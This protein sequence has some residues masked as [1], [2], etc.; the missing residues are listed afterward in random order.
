MRNTV[1]ILCSGAIL[2]GCAHSGVSSRTPSSTAAGV[3]TCSL[4]SRNTTV[5]TSQGLGYRPVYRIYDSEHGASFM[6]TDHPGCAEFGFKGDD[7]PEGYTAVDFDAVDDLARCQVMRAPPRMLSAATAHS[8]PVY[9]VTDTRTGFSALATDPDGC[10]LQGLVSERIEGF[11]ENYADL[12]VPG[13]REPASRD[14]QAWQRNGPCSVMSANTVVDVT[15]GAAGTPAFLVT[16]PASRGTFLSADYEGCRTQR[17]RVSAQ[18]TGTVSGKAAQTECQ[19]FGGQIVS[20]TE[21]K[22]LLPAYRVTEP[23]TKVSF[24]TV[25]PAACEAQGYRREPRP[26]AYV[27]F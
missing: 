24:L 23:S 21:I 20:T 15:P 2:T 25:D 4:L 3:A 16:D 9:R 22:G 27:N 7:T 13:G 8:R 10:A 14:A 1:L 19:I 5:V 18:A 12:A 11:V 26:E 17:Y 6:T